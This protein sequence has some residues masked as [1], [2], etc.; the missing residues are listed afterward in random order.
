MEPLD[1]L[2]FADAESLRVKLIEEMQLTD[3]VDTLVRYAAAI[4]GPLPG[5]TGHSVT[6]TKEE[7]GEIKVKYWDN[8]NV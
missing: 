6:I 4:L 3:D 5:T 7:S 8:G 2:A 1:T